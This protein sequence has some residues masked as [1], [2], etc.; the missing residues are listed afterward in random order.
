M[1]W[2]TNKGRTLICYPAK[3][4]RPEY[5]V[6]EDTQYIA[7][8]AFNMCHNLKKVM[9]PKS[10]SAISTAAFNYGDD[11]LSKNAMEIFMEIVYL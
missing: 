9:I 2:Q 1:K 10:V 5:T 4:E 3:L 8:S 6:P 11:G 7:Y